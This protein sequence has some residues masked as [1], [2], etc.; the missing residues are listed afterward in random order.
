[1][2]ALCFVIRELVCGQELAICNWYQL[3]LRIQP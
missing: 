2:Q 3:K 1:M